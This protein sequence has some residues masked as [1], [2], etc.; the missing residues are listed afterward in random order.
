MSSLHETAGTSDHPVAQRIRRAGPKRILALD[1]GGLRGV[2]A[3]AF[4]KRMETL[5]AAHYGVGENFRLRDHFDMIGGTSTGSIIATGLA[6]GWS[7]DYI[8]ATYDEMGWGILRRRAW[9]KGVFK[10]RYSGEALDTVL[11][12]Q[13]GDAKLGSHDITCALVIVTKRLDSG[14]V[15]ML[16]NNPFGRYYNQQAHE[17]SAANKDFPL[18]RIVRASGAAPTFFSP[19]FIQIAN[20]TAGFFIDGAVSPFNNPALLLF[21]VATTPSYGYGWEMHERTLQLISVGTGTRRTARNARLLRWLPSVG[22]GALALQTIIEDCSQ[23]AHMTLQSVSTVTIPW[24]IDREAGAL[25][26]DKPADRR[27]LS[28]TRLQLPLDRTWLETELGQQLT[29]KELDQLG[30]IDNPAGMTRLYE[31]GLAAADRLLRPEMLVPAPK[32][33]RPG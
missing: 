18:H 10:A 2:V 15:W 27:L 20:G 14:S 12:K 24:M 7:V 3:L 4:L 28:Y 21:L 23:Y 9:R 11:Q 1:G 32:A 6:L 8:R 5:L 29:E 30:R 25:D 26:H 13:I 31:L 19:E 16:H 17:S 22:M 33:A